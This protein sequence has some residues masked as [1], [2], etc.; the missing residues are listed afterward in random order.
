MSTKLCPKCGSGKVVAQ[1]EPMISGGDPAE[2]H[3]D[4]CSWSGKAS[5]LMVALQTK[6]A[7]GI[8]PALHVV[9]EVAKTYLQ[10]LAKDASKQIGLAMVSSGL[11]G[12]H[13][14]TS[15][16]RLVRAACLAAYYATLEE[17]EKMQKEI[18]DGPRK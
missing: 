18:K 2:A 12:L 14:K 8:D 5:E 16:G 9:E 3:C 15:L 11:V 13:D 4:G 1:T 7:A 6:P 17:I 10:L